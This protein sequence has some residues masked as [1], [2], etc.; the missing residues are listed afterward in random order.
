ML[1]NRYVATRSLD[2][3]C[4]G[5]EGD[6]PLL[7]MLADDRSVDE[8]VQQAIREEQVQ[9]A[10]FRLNENDRHVIAERYGLRDYC[11][12]TFRAIGERR[13]VCREKIR[14]DLRI[15]EHRLRVEL[16]TQMLAA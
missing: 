10:F 14:K 16:A 2:E 5:G 12:K 15:A 13:G 11:P 8:E 1:L 3:M 4:P 6:T 7:E 9:L